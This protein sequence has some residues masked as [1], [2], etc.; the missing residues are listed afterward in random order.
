[1]RTNALCNLQAMLLG[2]AG[3]SRLPEVCHQ[4]HSCGTGLQDW[5]RGRRAHTRGLQVRS[6]VPLHAVCQN[7]V[8]QA[9]DYL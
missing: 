6:V 8:E 7:S 4:L 3:G 1:M 2:N 5:L 9:S